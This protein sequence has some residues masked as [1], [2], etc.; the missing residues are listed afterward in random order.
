MTVGATV[1][2]N[3][4]ANRKIIGASRGRRIQVRR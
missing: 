3:L 4:N 2:V 1:H